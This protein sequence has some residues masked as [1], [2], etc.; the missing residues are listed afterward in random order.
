[1]EGREPEAVAAVRD[2]VLSQVERVTIR[3]R[4]RRGKTFDPSPRG[5]RLA[6]TT[7]PYTGPVTSASVLRRTSV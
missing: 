7:P 1:M 3:R 2:L 4:E 5:D 6:L